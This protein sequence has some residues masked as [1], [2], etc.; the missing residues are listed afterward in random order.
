MA[1]DL[2]L[3]VDPYYDD[4]N[5]EK[6]FHQI[7]FRPAVPVQAREL[8]QLQDILQNQIQRFG[9]N[10][11]AT[12][13]IIKGCNFIFDDSYDYAKILDLR[14]DGVATNV[15]NYVGL[16][17]YDATSN[18]QAVVVNSVDGFESQNPDLKTL[19]LKYINS[20]MYANAERKTFTADT[21]LSFYANAATTSTGV[22]IANNYQANLDVK[23]AYSNTNPIG[24][25]YAVSVTEGIIYQKG[26]FI[27]VAN[28]LTA[29]VS[30]YSN[31]PNN[32][33]LG[34][35]TEENIVTELSDPSLNDNASGYT[36]YN[37]PGA[38]RL[39]LIPQL[40][41]ANTDAIPTNNFFSAVEWQSGNVVRL[42]QQTEY[43]QINREMAR[44]TFEE[45]GNYVVN[46]FSVVSNPITSNTTHFNLITSAGLAFV[47]GY[48]VE[49]LNNRG[50]AFRK[51]TDTVSVTDQY[52]NTGYGNYIL[53]NNA[54]GTFD[55]NIGAKINLRDTAANSI[56]TDSYSLTPTGNVI[57]TARILS[58]TYDNGTP[59]TASGRYR[60]YLT[61][62]NMNSGFTFANVR[63]V[64]Y[65]SSY[66]GLADIVL[67][68]NTAM[69][70]DGNK[71]SLVIPTSK[72]AVTAVSNINYVYRTST[73]ASSYKIDATTGAMSTIT[74]PAG[75]IFPYGTGTLSSELE[76]RVVVIPQ[77]SAN[78]ATPAKSGTVVANDNF[79]VG[80]STKFVS[81]YEVNDYIN[82][83]GVAKRIVSIANDTY[84]T[85]SS[86]LASN[87]AV[88]NSHA[89]FYPANVPIPMSERNSTIYLANTSSMS[90]QLVS[91]GGTNET[92]SSN[93]NIILYYDIQKN[94]SS[95][96][97]KEVKKNQF[98][99]I[100]TALNA[101]GTG[102]LTAVNTSTTITGNSTAFDS[103]ISPGYVLYS[104]ANVAIGTVLSVTNSTSLTLTANA[105]INYSNDIFTY[106]APNAVGNFGPWSLG[107]PD[108]YKINGVYRTSGNTYSNSSTY[109]VTSLF[110]LRTGQKDGMYDLAFLELN[111]AGYGQILNGDKLLVDLSVFKA[112][113]GSG[114]GFFSRTS[115]PIDD[116]NTAN[117]AAIRTIDIPVYKTSTGTSLPLRDAFDFRPQVT[118][119]AI[120]TSDPTTATVN[121]AN[122][123][124]FS[125]GEQYIVSPN[126][127]IGYSMTYNVG[128]IDKLVVSSLGDFLAVEGVP[129]EVTVPPADVSSAMTLAQ[130]YIPPY[131]SL[132]VLEN[133][134][135]NR[136][137]YMIKTYTTQNRRYTMKDISEIDKRLKNVEYYT[138]LNVLE[139][140]TKNM[141]IVSGVDGTDRF[142]NGIFVD[143][144]TDDI[145]ADKSNLE[146]K[147][148]YDTNDSAIIP[149]FRQSAIG[150]KY[151]TGAQKTGDV[152]TLPYTE[153]EYITQ[154]GRTRSRVCTDGAYNFR[155]VG[156]ATPGY[157]TL[158]DLRYP[159]V[160]ITPSLTD[161][162]KFSLSPASESL[163]VS[164][165][166]NVSFC[167]DVL[168]GS[169]YVASPEV[170]AV[171]FPS[172]N[173][174]FDYV[175]LSEYQY[176]SII[177]NNSYVAAPTAFTTAF[178]NIS[179]WPFAYFNAPFN[180]LYDA[181]T[182]R[183]AMSAY[184]FQGRRQV[185]GGWST[186][187]FSPVRGLVGACWSGLIQ[188]P[189]SGSW[190]FT[191]TYDDGM[192]LII[193]GTTVF[194]DWVDGTARTKSGSITL[195][196][197]KK[198]MF[199][200]YYYN[201]GSQNSAACVLQAQ[202]ASY[203]GGALSMVPYDWFSVPFGNLAENI[204]PNITSFY[205]GTPA[206]PGAPGGWP[207]TKETIAEYNKLV[208]RYINMGDLNT[209]ALSKGNYIL[210]E[211]EVIQGIK[212]AIASGWVQTYGATAGPAI[213]AGG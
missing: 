110:N 2:D 208:N 140:K 83:N 125:S 54:V 40:A 151:S 106:T 134:A 145:S 154:T 133:V 51:G 77:T 199:K 141:V 191:G 156:S 71:S 41:I 105:N 16:I 172:A 195:D 73:W 181:L 67:Q 136:P 210:N 173:P 92:L 109:D 127:V 146:F 121:P 96:I 32:I 122:T 119:T 124:N 82:I 103:Q 18:L 120:Y 149:L 130:V 13:T 188:V 9:D 111:Q 66:D 22:A 78:V 168:A 178:S 126:Q 68:S 90:M 206:K 163:Y 26:Y 50:T 95:A 91:K 7:L 102:T 48:R 167:R 55:F 38:H 86:N 97:T 49:N 180:R 198:Y 39:Q 35:T 21:T 174:A 137:E 205:T 59:G 27:R 104:K 3:N 138:S 177:E 62:V 123:S 116:V 142:K 37:A 25:G 204:I 129:G 36:N 20:G 44:R 4:F 158:P 193:D 162:T 179:K 24:K 186:A 60:A 144:F 190:T 189:Y 148:G 184:N 5:E 14:V 81:E 99:K 57:G 85:L 176:G 207:L 182:R 17:A 80:T 70:Y 47:E 79:V 117:T 98:V 175:G 58:V 115:Y 108:V 196:S 150:F 200:L 43:S 203:N 165:T 8:T 170:T 33:T 42:R 88:A 164:N 69:V 152:V 114:V 113:T 128:R 160:K 201:N 23:V 169:P 131:P 87:V 52:L 65:D 45:S 76:R 171:D 53:I 75:S 46:P 157:L 185:G 10:V 34:F 147:I 19:Y 28:N 100:D 15:D 132:T 112:S 143:D 101:I 202:N 107:L 153:V 63:S 93:L 11:L 64:S 118:N 212:A 94:N 56:G 1:L 74:L 61:D 72:F 29:V 166:L 89:K 135:E 139:N 161:P 194:T 197:T 84:L 209:V 30:K 183:F 192:V 12:G 155:G 187:P 159:T 213:S 31:T 6:N 211:A